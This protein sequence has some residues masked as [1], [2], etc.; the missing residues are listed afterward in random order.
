MR[1]IRVFKIKQILRYSHH[2]HFTCLF[3]FKKELFNTATFYS[4][5]LAENSYQKWSMNRSQIYQVNFEEF[6]A[7]NDLL[8]PKGLNPIGGLNCGSQ[9]NEGGG[10]P[11]QLEPVGP[12]GTPRG[13]LGWSN[14]EAS[15]VPRWEGKWVPLFPRMEVSSTSEN[16]PQ[17]SML[18]SSSSDKPV[19][20]INPVKTN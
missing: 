12:I 9:G 18:L 13:N 16:S 11:V 1:W 6:F 17:T 19:E 8:W 2:Y 10:P 15:G 14:A 20:T 5:E 7:K 4:S 3:G